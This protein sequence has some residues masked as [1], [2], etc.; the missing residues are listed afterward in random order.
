MAVSSA[1]AAWTVT[2]VGAGSL[3]ETVNGIC[4]SSPLRT[5]I[6]ASAID[7]LRP[8]TAH[9]DVL[10][11]GAVGATFTQSAELS[12]V[13]CGKPFPVVLRA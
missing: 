6:V 5:L 11:R 12:P 4:W 7:R 2:S 10:A 13:D 9:G 3:S 1:V 8:S